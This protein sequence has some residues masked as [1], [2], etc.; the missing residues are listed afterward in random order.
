MTTITTTPATFKP[1]VHRP[2]RGTDLTIEIARRLVHDNDLRIRRFRFHNDDMRRF[3]DGVR[4]A[5]YVVRH[6]VAR[7]WLYI[8]DPAVAVDNDAS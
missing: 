2:A 1:P 5:G 7:A 8:D 4:Q 6:D 3:I